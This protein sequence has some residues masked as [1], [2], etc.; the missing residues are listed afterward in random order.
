MEHWTSSQLVIRAEN[1]ACVLQS[2]DVSRHARASRELSRV[3]A[4][5]RTRD[6]ATAIGWLLKD[7][8]T[9]KREVM[10]MRHRAATQHTRRKTPKAKKTVA[11]APIAEVISDRTIPTV[12]T[13]VAVTI[14]TEV[15][16]MTVTATQIPRKNGFW[17]K[18]DGYKGRIK[19]S[20]DAFVAEAPSTL[21]LEIAGAELTVRAVRV[22]RD[23]A[24]RAEFLA[25]LTADQKRQMVERKVAAAERRLAKLRQKA[26]EDLAALNA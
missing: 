7:E 18:L 25:S 22:P 26:E 12:P 8:T 20:K 13:D 5:L 17:Y 1:L 6:D 10:A 2:A 9:P 19:I 16:T 24:A 15:Q 21:T 4:I 3:T 11:S 14:P 23:K